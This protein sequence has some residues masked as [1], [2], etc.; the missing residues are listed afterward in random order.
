VGKRSVSIKTHI[1]RFTLI[2]VSLWPISTQISAQTSILPSST[3][4][5]PA[6]TQIIDDTQQLPNSVN[7]I[8][9]SAGLTAAAAA[10]I[11]FTYH[12][13]HP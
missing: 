5:E 1:V 13:I 3:P 12:L 11:A 2:A 6:P 10:F 9:P 8:L 7:Q 4:R